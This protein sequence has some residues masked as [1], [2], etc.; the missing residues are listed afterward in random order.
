MS[1][2]NVIQELQ[3]RNTTMLEEIEGLK[4][5]SIFQNCSNGSDDNSMTVMNEKDILIRK[6]RDEIKTS[7]TYTKQL[8]EDNKNLRDEID[9][10]NRPTTL[11]LVFDENTKNM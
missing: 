6:L 8:E 3:I 7:K 9:N 11:T 1:K 2:D 5:N 10:N 4:E